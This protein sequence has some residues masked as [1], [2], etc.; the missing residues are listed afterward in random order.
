MRTEFGTLQGQSGVHV[1]RDRQLSNQAPV[2]LS[3]QR[4]RHQGPR[5]PQARPRIHPQ[6]MGQ[7]A[8]GEGHP[9]ANRPLPHHPLDHPLCALALRG[10][11][12]T[13]RQLP[14]RQTDRLQDPVQDRDQ[15]GLERRHVASGQ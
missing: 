15:I 1:Q 10:H 6:Q 5:D 7:A 2:R 13:L 4:E 3:W 9:E 11:L 8:Q 14:E 12:P